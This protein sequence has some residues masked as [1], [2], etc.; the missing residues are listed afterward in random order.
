MPNPSLRPITDQ[1]RQRIC[2]AGSDAPVTFHETQLADEFGLSRTPVREILQY[3]SYQGLVETRPG[4]GTRATRLDPAARR[5][6][7]VTYG[8]LLRAAATSVTGRPVPEQVQID[9]MG[10]ARVTE[11]GGDR[12]AETFVRTRGRVAGTKASIVEDEILRFSLEAAQWRILRWQ[13]R[14]FA[15]DPDIVWAGLSLALERLSAAAAQ[16]ADCAA[17]LVAAADLAEADLATLSEAAA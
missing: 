13:S 6:H 8:A 9:L 15:T 2:L 10:L 17:L 7:Q 4:V 12:S 11:A 3:L 16:G 1:L 14:D 5:S